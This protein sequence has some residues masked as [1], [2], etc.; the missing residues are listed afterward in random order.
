V[1]LSWEPGSGT[2]P[3]GYQLQRYAGVFSPGATPEETI[4]IPSTSSSYSDTPT[5]ISKDSKYQ[6]QL[7]ASN[8]VGHSSA[9]SNILD[10]PQA[11][12]APTNVVAQWVREYSEARV[13]WNASDHANSYEVVLDKLDLIGATSPE[14]HKNILSTSFQEPLTG[15]WYI[16]YRYEVSANNR[17][18]SSNSTTS[19]WL[20]GPPD[21][22]TPPTPTPFPTPTPT[23]THRPVIRN[24]P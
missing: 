2:Q 23:G 14:D 9:L 18:G 1:T 4:A 13:T 15:E 20:P 17:F 19:N 7:I 8:A 11:P 5:D 22:P 12:P 24:Q 16:A 21:P 10:P 6:Y 3:T